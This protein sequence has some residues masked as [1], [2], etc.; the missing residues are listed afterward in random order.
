MSRQGR[1]DFKEASNHL[2]SCNGYDRSP[3]SQSAAKPCLG[4]VS[5]EDI[6]RGICAYELRAR[7][8]FGESPVKTEGHNCLGCNSN[9]QSGK[10]TGRLTACTAYTPMLSVLERTCSWHVRSQRLLDLYNRDRTRLKPEELHCLEKCDAKKD[11]LCIGYIDVK[12][13][14]EETCIHKV[15]IDNK[16]RITG[17]AEGLEKVCLGCT[18]QCLSRKCQ[19]SYISVTEMH[20]FEVWNELHPLTPR[21]SIESQACSA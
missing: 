8:G 2:Y 21:K 1:P 20:H 17:V 12:H 10:D 3:S 11:S 13:V 14:V 9:H 7:N 4:F 19:D 6:Q 16:L 18:G 15:N 5:V